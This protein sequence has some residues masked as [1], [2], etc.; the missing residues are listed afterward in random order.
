VVVVNVVAAANECRDQTIR[1][2]ELSLTLQVVPELR[3]LVRS[4]YSVI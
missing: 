2:G 4:F 3:N 1:F